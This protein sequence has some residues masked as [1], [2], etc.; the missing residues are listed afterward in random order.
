MNLTVNSSLLFREKT[1]GSRTG[2]NQEGARKEI[3][4]RREEKESTRGNGSN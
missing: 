4:G 1:K 2:R 3:E